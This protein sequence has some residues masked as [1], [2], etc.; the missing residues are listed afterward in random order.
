MATINKTCRESPQFGRASVRATLFCR[1]LHF[2]ANCFFGGFGNEKICLILTR[3][4]RS[5]YNAGVA[6]ASVGHDNMRSVAPG[7]EKDAF[8]GANSTGSRDELQ[9]SKTRA[10]RRIAR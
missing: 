7:F 4:S 10:R 6:D 8:A 3:V 5:D 9:S 2:S 1:W